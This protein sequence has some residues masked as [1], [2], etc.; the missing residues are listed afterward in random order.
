VQLA[1]EVVE[2][3]SAAPKLIA[4]HAGGTETH[5]TLQPLADLARRVASNRLPSREDGP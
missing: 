5:R 2:P 3:A 1:I 4:H